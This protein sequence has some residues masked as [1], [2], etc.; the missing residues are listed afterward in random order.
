RFIPVTSP[1]TGEVITY[2]PRSKKE[3]VDL[4]V[5][6]AKKA[7]PAWSNR[8]VKDRAQIIIR[9]HQLV[10]RDQEI[11]ADLI[12]NEHGKTKSEALADVAK[13]NETVEYAISLP[14][15][16]Q[17]KILEVSRGVICRDQKLPLGVVASIVPFNFPFMV[18]MWTLPIAITLGNTMVLKP[19]EKVPMTMNKVMSLL[20]EAGLPSGVVN[21]VNGGAETATSLV[22]HP[23]VKAITFVGTSHVAKLLESKGRNLGKRVLALGGAKNHLVAYPDCNVDMTATDI[24]ASFTGCS[25][26]RCMA[27]SV[28]LTIGEQQA[29]LDRIVE[30]AAGILP[31]QVAGQM[32][33]VIDRI[34]LEKIVRYIDEAEAG[35]AKI[36]LDGRR[37]VKEGV[38]VGG[39]DTKGG[40]WVG[41]TVILHRKRTD[42]ALHDEIFGPVLSVFVVQSK[43]EAV[44]IENQSPYGNAAAIY[45]SD[46]GVAEWF[47]KRF[48]AGMIGVNIGVPVPREPFSFGGINI[49]KYGDSDITG[50]GGINFFTYTKKVTTKWAPPPEQSWL[51]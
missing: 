46:G 31:G 22:E 36:L 47:Y 12:V 35:G 45:T 30:R 39:L 26:Q 7:F 9:F 25:G 32:G 38:V 17:G 40:F 11:L 51:C 15:L 49:S 4:A 13:G 16:I 41:P 43:E 50:E 37:W 34:S 10:V 33:P 19:S 24:V 5:A 20:R 27:A 44:E 21:L 6:S 23:D 3:D 48:S 2:A 28:L 1:A 42:P 18:P 14:Q 8:T 29:L